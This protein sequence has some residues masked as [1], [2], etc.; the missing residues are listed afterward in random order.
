LN[1][2]DKKTN[3]PKFFGFS[4]VK[5]IVVTIFLILFIAAM[6]FVVIPMRGGAGWGNIGVWTPPVYFCV[7]FFVTYNLDILQ[8][9]LK[10]AYRP[11][12]GIFYTGMAL[13]VAVFSVFC[14]LIMGYTSE[15]IPE[16][17]DIVIVLG[18][19][20]KGHNPGNLLRHRLDAAVD[21]MNK[22]PAA[23]CIVAGGQGPDEIVQEAVVMKKYMAENGI[24]PDRIF[25]E[26]KS[27][28]SYE[29]LIF[30]KDVIEKSNLEHKNIVI[31]TSSYHVP[32]AV[33]IA[34]RVYQN[35]EIYAVKSNSP[36]AL[37][38]AGIVREFFAFVKSFIFDRV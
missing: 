32:R 27:S 4:P 31:V 9:L 21:T 7:L 16:N 33:L 36:F 37:F 30:A 3:K 26:D 18:C 11:L 38:S 23:I 1:F 29:N 25:E 5:K 12:I 6:I 13:F 34:K 8:K 15:K 17:P 10:K 2:K 20:V 22:Y 24:D 19:Q 14:F 35:S 28:S